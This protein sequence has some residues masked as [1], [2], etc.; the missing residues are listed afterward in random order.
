MTKY[1]PYEYKMIELQFKAYTRT[2][3]RRNE[4]LLS[5]INGLTKAKNHMLKKKEDS[6]N[7][8]ADGHPAHRPASIAIG[9]NV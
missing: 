7:N 3:K 4:M 6:V 9:Q 8:R 2:M 5:E 1:T